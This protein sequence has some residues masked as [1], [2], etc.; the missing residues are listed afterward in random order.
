MSSNKPVLADHRRKGKRLVPPLLQLGPFTDTPWRYEGFPECLWLG[1]L[2]EQTGP[3]ESLDFLLSYGNVVAGLS[4]AKPKPFI[5]LMSEVQRLSESEKAAI[6]GA[7][8]LNG[9]RRFVVDRMGSFLS[10][11]PS[12]PIS[13]LF[14]TEEI[15]ANF[16][17]EFLKTLTRVAGEFMDKRSKLSTWAHGH[18]I[19]LAFRLGFLKIARGISLGNLPALESYPVTEESQKVAASVRAAGGMIIQ[20]RLESVPKTWRDYFWMRNRSISRCL[21]PGENNE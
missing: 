1:L 2:I 19:A 7:M 12:C 16:D 18:I 5:V 10:I 20:Q 14:D 15:P 21:F 4:S 11:Y 13:F 8:S 9:L 6:R 17:P 3:K